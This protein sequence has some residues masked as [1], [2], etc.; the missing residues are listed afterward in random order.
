MAQ[1]LIPL[2]VVE[3]QNQRAIRRRHCLF[4]FQVTGITW[5]PTH[6]CRLAT[7]VFGKATI[8]SEIHIQTR[9]AI[10]THHPVKASS[11]PGG[12]NAPRK[13]AHASMIAAA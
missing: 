4:Q 2:I 3:K 7:E 6:G 8:S 13:G 9:Q 5:K 11:C 10:K 1:V 12:K